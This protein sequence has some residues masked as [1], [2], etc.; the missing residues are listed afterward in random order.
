MREGRRERAVVWLAFVVE[1]VGVERREVLQL[2]WTGRGS[3]V[4]GSSGGVVKES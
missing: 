2:D 3:E 1:S 4:V